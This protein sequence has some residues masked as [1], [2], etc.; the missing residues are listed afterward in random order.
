MVE[1]RRRKTLLSA[2][3]VSAQRIGH[4]PGLIDRKRLPGRKTDPQPDRTVNGL[5]RRLV[6]ELVNVATGLAGA[7]VVAARTIDQ[8]HPLGA[9]DQPIEI[10]GI[11]PFVVLRRRQAV[12]VAQVVRNEGGRDG[13]V[14][15]KRI[16]VDRQDQHVFEIE[17]PGLQDSHDLDAC[18]RLSFVRNAQ[19]LQ[20]PPQQR[21]EHGHRNFQPGIGQ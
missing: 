19:R 21:S 17:V 14:A 1:R 12:S 9:L 20:R 7:F 2:V 3:Q 5:V 18:Q 11:N 10:V 13:P 15:G 16:V 8:M 4:P 6:F